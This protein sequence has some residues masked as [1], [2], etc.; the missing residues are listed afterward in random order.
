MMGVKKLFTMM[1]V[2]PM[3]FGMTSYTCKKSEAKASTSTDTNVTRNDSIPNPKEG[4]SKQ[5]V[6]KGTLKCYPDFPSKNISSRAVSVWL[7]A[8]YKEGDACDVL[9][10]HDG[11]MLFDASATW[12]HQEW[13]VDE[14]LGELITTKKVR[15]TIVV[16]IDNTSDRL[17]EY[18]PDKV[19]DL[20]ATKPNSFAPKGDAY[21]KFIVNE[22]K[23]F[24]DHRFQPLTTKE[25]T[26]MMG[27]SM[28]GLISMYALCEYPEV[29][30][31]AACLST[32]S[33]MNLLV[34]GAEKILAEALRSYIKTNLPKPNS[35]FI[36]MDRGSIGID[37]SY[38]SAQTQIDKII[39]D[40]GWDEAHFE[41]LLFLGHDHNEKCWAGRLDKP[42]TFLLSNKR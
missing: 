8:G 39:S 26:F 32:H 20:L 16:A 15:P 5:K 9:Y 14:V 22:L 21:L 1:L 35:N 23:P 41:T 31:G 27:S 12:N 10:M 28:G 11:Q 19:I 36:Y 38:A 2:L 24:I 4:I 37:A 13:K 42:I 40:A 17:L 3:L 18:F 7:P 25:H 33:S 6:S 34:Q 30:G 29:F